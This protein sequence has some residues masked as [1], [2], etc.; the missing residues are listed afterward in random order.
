MPEPIV[1]N[2]AVV[3]EA[4]SCLTA[5]NKTSHPY[6]FYFFLLA[7]VSEA[8]PCFTSLNS[9]N[10]SRPPPPSLFCAV[11]SVASTCFTAVRGLKQDA[12]APFEFNF[13]FYI[14]FFN[15]NFYF[16]WSGADVF[17]YDGW[18]IF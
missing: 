18:T 9:K 2:C 7:V 5:S 15:F 8:S 3:P 4:S 1:T 17:L 6:F 12:A 16:R 14:R 13:Y 10:M 11:V